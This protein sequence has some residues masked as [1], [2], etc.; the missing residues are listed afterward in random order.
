MCT[1]WVRVEVRSGSVVKLNRFE[2]PWK[3]AP[4]TSPR[5]LRNRRGTFRLCSHAKQCEMLRTGIR[6]NWGSVG[7][8]VFDFRPDFSPFLSGYFASM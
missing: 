1:E 7:I 3:V 2:L 8:D 6:G 4:S 5:F